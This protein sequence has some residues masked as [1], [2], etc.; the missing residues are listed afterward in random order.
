MGY[1]SPM[2]PEGTA[3]S[4]QLT[5]QKL[6]AHKMLRFNH[7]Q[8]QKLFFAKHS[9]NSRVKPKNGLTP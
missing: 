2:L 4:C 5:A 9:A 6:T 7:L 1:A 8:T 3:S